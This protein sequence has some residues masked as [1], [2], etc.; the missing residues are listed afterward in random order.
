M[1]FNVEELIELCKNSVVPKWF[2]LNGHTIGFPAHGDEFLE[3]D[4]ST[5][6]RKLAKIGGHI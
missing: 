3:S 5:L 2:H 6:R 4:T 1:F